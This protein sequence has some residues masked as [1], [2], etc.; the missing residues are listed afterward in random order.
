MSPPYSRE[1]NPH[2]LNRYWLQLW[3]GQRRWTFLAFLIICNGRDP[4]LFII[5]DALIGRHGHIHM[6]MNAVTFFDRFGSSCRVGISDMLNRH[7]PVMLIP[8][9]VLSGWW[10]RN[11]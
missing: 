5:G 6:D 4:A 8:D 7:D 1:S 9:H 2:Y 3:Y 10:P 11:H